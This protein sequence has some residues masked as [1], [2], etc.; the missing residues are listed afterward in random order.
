MCMLPQPWICVLND[1]SLWFIDV[2]TRRYPGKKNSPTLPA[3]ESAL[4]P[5][6]VYLEQLTEQT[7]ILC[8]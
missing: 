1:R 4:I 3:Q 8:K 7:N 2:G 5:L 6:V